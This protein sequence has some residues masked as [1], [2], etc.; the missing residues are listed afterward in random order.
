MQN[1]VDDLVKKVVIKYYIIEEAAMNE[2][3]RNKWGGGGREM[4]VGLKL[5]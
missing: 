5:K 1:R 2:R 4:V 3:G